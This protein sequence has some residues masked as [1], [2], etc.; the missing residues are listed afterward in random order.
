MNFELTNNILNEKGLLGSTLEVLNLDANLYSTLLFQPVSAIEYTDQY[1]RNANRDLAN[2]K[3]NGFFDISIENNVELAITPEYSCPWSIIEQLIEENRLPQESKLWIVGCESIQ[4]QQLLDIINDHDEIVWIYDEDK[5]QQNLINN[6]FFD[7]VCYLFKTRTQETN[8]LRTIAIV[9]FKTHFM[10]NNPWERDNYIAGQNIYVLENQNQ[11]SRLLT[12]ICSDTLHQNFNI[13]AGLPQGPPD[14]S[15]YPY[16][17][18]HIQLNQSPFNIDFRRYRGDIYNRN[19]YDKEVIC[20]NWGRF[21]QMKATT[22]WNNYGGSAIFT[23]STEL[24]LRDER[25]NH[26]HDKGLYYTRWKTRRSNVYF[27][28]FDEYIFCLRNTKPSQAMEYGVMQ[29]RTGPE[30]QFIRKWDNGR[31]SWDEIEITNDGFNELC[32]SIEGEGNFNTLLDGELSRINLERLIALSVGKAVQKDW[33]SIQ[34]NKFF[35]IDDDG[36]NKRMTFTQDPCIEMHE[37][38]RKNLILFAR[39]ANHIVVHEEYFP[40]VLSDLKG[41]CKVSYLLGD[42]NTSFSMNLFPISGDGAAATGIYIGDVDKITAIET[43][44]K[45]TNLFPESQNW[46]RIVVW[47]RDA[48]GYKYAPSKKPKITDN[49]SKPF[50][51]IITDRK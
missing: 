24:D 26:N 46:T 27:L 16:L 4:S 8:E 5:V 34:N 11:S 50:N 33:Y 23:K 12:F 15:I 28:N 7:P 13:Q 3:F 18:I 1:I 6:H 32:L 25:I 44:E 40:D 20:L 29:G 49:A 2:Q 22:N 38:R 48:D 30:V 14:F 19:Q 37:T 47:Y 31:H 51:S 17:I 21:V 39:L 43:Y 36:V 42:N 10:G 41:N 35:L 45:T 9:Q